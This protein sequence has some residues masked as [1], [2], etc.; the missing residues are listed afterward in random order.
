ME[1][2]AIVTLEEN[3]KV[4]ATKGQTTVSML[5]AGR[6]GFSDSEKQEK[7]V[8]ALCKLLDIEFNHKPQR[9]PSTGFFE[10]VWVLE[11]E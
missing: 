10:F 4:F 9:L 11:S 8:R 7:A 6:R 2:L 3:G 5:S 1:E